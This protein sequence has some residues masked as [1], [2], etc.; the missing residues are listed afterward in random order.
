MPQMSIDIIGMSEFQTVL[1]SIVKVARFL[2]LKPVKLIHMQIG[3]CHR[4]S[5]YIYDTGVC[6]GVK[7]LHSCGK[8]EHHIEKSKN[9]FI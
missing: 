6:F 3:L 9:C 5:V 4:C 7:I 1:L 8:H 2:N